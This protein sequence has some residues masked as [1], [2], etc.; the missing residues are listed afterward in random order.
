M[1]PVKNGMKFT[2]DVYIFRAESVRSLGSNLLLALSHLS[3]AAAEQEPRPGGRID[4]SEALHDFAHAR[5]EKWS[6]YLA[7]L[8]GRLWKIVVFSSVL[9]FWWGERPSLPESWRLL[10]IAIF[11]V[12]RKQ[13][14]AF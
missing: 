1:R 2:L 11:A 6:V 7:P 5:E 13:V 14:F 9:L 8:A 3:L 10:Y 12:G 4:V